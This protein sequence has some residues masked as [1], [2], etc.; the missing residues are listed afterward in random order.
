MLYNMTYRVTNNF[1]I[2]VYILQLVCPEEKQEQ[3]FIKHHLC[4]STNLL[5]FTQSLCNSCYFAHFMCS[6]INIQKG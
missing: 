6:E 1:M 3:P 4:V 5:F 2:I